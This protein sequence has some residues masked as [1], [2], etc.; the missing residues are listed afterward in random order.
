MGEKQKNLLTSDWVWI[1]I[2]KF[3]ICQTQKFILTRFQ[4]SP[5][6]SGN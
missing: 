2:W 3:L 6:L 4:N 5:L 1:K